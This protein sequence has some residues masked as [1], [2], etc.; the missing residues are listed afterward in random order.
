MTSYKKE[1]EIKQEQ[2]LRQ[3]LDRLP[4]FCTD[5]FNYCLG[6]KG[7]SI[8]TMLQYANNLVVFFQYL[9]VSNPSF[10]SVKSIRLDDLNRLTPKD[11][12][13][14]MFYLRNYESTEGE[15]IT[16]SPKSRSNKLSALRS[17]FQYYFAFG[18]MDSNPAKMI[19]SPKSKGKRL[20]N[21]EKD[22]LDELLD[23]AE[24]GS[25]LTTK[26]QLFAKN[27]YMRDSAIIAVLSGTGIRVSE[28]VGI[29]LEDIDW[30]NRCIRVI[31]KGG[32][33]DVVYFGQEV[34]R[35]LSDY[36]EYERKTD[37]DGEHALFLSSRH[38]IHG[39]LSVRSVERLV[40][41]YG[42]SSVTSKKVT[43]HTLRRTFGT[44]YYNDT[45]DIYLTADA[46][47]H[48]NVQV[49]AEHYSSIS[50]ERKKNAGQ[51]SDKLL[52]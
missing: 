42:Q 28:L 48:K 16:N 3:I 19:D 7:N 49:T 30:K 4:P 2:Q 41:K 32:K 27:T 10:P 11:I 24:T 43:P 45:G 39:R 20:A 51:F 31:R 12:Q 8:Q 5:Y 50:D 23:S 44:G 17:F 35:Y 33:E 52:N 9:L 34:E 1:K 14:F 13:E 6:T 21:L 36:I 18:G 29:N 22:E 40:K 46:L 47:G 25:G 26:Q 38:G 37:N 15:V